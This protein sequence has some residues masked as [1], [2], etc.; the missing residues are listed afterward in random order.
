MDIPRGARFVAKRDLK[1]SGLTRWRAPFSGDFDCVIP[2]GTVLKVLDNKL[3]TAREFSCCPE[4]YEELESR[5]VPAQDRLN[6]NYDGYY[7]VFLESD[8][9]YSLR[10]IA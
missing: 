4:S 10:W 5:L 6:D 3:P 7:F 1:V 8:I 2:A 9:G